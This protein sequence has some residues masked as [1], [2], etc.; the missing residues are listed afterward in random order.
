M[1]VTHVRSK[2]KLPERDEAEPNV[3]GLSRGRGI[4]FDTEARPRQR[5]DEAEPRQREAKRFIEAA[6]RQ[7]TYLKDHITASISSYHCTEG[8]LASGSQ[9]KVSNASSLK[10]LVVDKKSMRQQ[11]ILHGWGQCFELPSVLSHALLW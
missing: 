9:H 7:G 2:R 6:S 10:S 1:Q 11:V 3:T 8:V 4:W 5:E